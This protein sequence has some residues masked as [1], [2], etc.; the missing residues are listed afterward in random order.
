M[1]A[2][3][4]NL[5]LYL[6]R[7]SCV[8][9][10]H[11]CPFVFYMWIVYSYKVIKKYLKQPIFCK[12]T[13]NVHDLYYHDNH[14]PNLKGVNTMFI[15]ILMN[16]FLLVSLYV[17]LDENVYLVKISIYIVDVLIMC[18]QNEVLIILGIVVLEVYI[19]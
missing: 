7:T 14:Q 6:I 3:N 12:H 1:T 18:N 13:L 15:Y 2:V 8:V 11:T 5:I 9:N 16:R 4:Q 19:I 10:L 17:T